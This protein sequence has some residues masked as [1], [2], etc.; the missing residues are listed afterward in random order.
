[1]IKNYLL[2]ERF[3]FLDI[4]FCGAVGVSAFYN[5]FV[6]LEFIFTAIVIFIMGL[7]KELLK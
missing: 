2:D 4:I 1:M 3:D 7:I 6:S 5:G